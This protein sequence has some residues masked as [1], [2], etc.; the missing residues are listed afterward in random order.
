MGRAE[1][2]STLYGEMLDL[3]ACLAIYN[4][5]AEQEDK[6]TLTRLEDTLEVT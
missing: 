4:G 6:K 5:G 3:I 1:T 2:L